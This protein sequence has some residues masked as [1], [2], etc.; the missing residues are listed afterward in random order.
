MKTPVRE[1]V[2]REEHKLAETVDP[3]PGVQ[4]G[5]EMKAI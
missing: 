4:C 3:S 2:A 5:E 1:G